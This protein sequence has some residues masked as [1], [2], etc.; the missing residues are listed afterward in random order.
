[1]EINRIN[2]EA[3]EKEMK[4]KKL[5]DENIKLKN[6]LKDF[7]KTF[8]NNNNNKRIDVKTRE[9]QC[10][11]KFKVFDKNVQVIPHTSDVKTQTE[12]MRI[13]DVN[14]EDEE[15]EEREN[16]NKNQIMYLQEQ[17]EVL[18]LIIKDLKKN[19]NFEKKFNYYLQNHEH[20]INDS[21]KNILQLNDKFETEIENIKKLL[22]Q[23]QNQRVQEETIMENLETTMTCLKNKLLNTLPPK[24]RHQNH[25]DHLTKENDVG[26]TGN[27]N[28][29]E[30]TQR[31][32]ME[33]YMEGNNLNGNIN[34]LNRFERNILEKIDDVKS[35]FFD[36]I[37][38]LLLLYENLNKDNFFDEILIII[39]IL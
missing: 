17:N 23:E 34:L 36:K 29:D 11:I 13:S 7:E 33:E 10:D 16:Y 3:C 1:M 19:N 32:Q 20:D 38:S 5:E 9:I 15:A 8:N 25:V 22:I 27:N 6:Y 21:K 26:D 4:M 14:K 35:E 31:N 18:K 30:T 12:T 2:E 28:N 37:K 39:I 24:Q